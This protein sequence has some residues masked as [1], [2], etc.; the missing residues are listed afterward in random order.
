MSLATDQ[1][2]T[3]REQRTEKPCNPKR[4]FGDKLL[5][6]HLVPPAA[7]AYIAM[8]MKEGAR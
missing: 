6:L 1:P 5:P 8:A 7:I 4:A 2:A 3:V